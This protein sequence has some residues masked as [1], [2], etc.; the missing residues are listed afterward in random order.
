MPDSHGRIIDS[1]LGEFRGICAIPH[2]SGR[3]EK[4][5][6]YLSE[7]LQSLG[8]KVTRDW[9]GNILGVFPGKCKNPDSPWVML[10]A[11][12]DMVLSGD[13]A[14]DTPIKPIEKNDFII[15]ADNTTLGADNG[16]GI[17]VILTL[18]TEEESFPLPLKVL[19]TVEEEIGLKGAKEV[20]EEW[21]S[22]VKYLINTDGFDGSTVIV[23]CKGGVRETFESVIVTENDWGDLKNEVMEGEI[24]FLDFIGGH[25]GADI[26]KGRCNAIKALAELLVFLNDRF[27]IRIREIEGGKSH[28]AIPGEAMCRFQFLACD[29]N[30]IEGILKEWESETIRRYSEVDSQG[31]LTYNLDLPQ[32]AGHKE[33]NEARPEPW[34]KDTQRKVIRF[35][36]SIEDGVYESGNGEV[37]ASSNLGFLHTESSKVKVGVMVRCD[38]ESTAESIGKSHLRLAEETGFSMIAEGYHGWQSKPG[39]KL[40][41]G[42]EEAYMDLNGLPIRK[43]VAKVGLETA[44]FHGISPA[45]EM[46]CLGAD[47]QNA[48][49]VKERV[50]VSSLAGFYNLI[51]STLPKLI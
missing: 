9:K 40:L 28:N 47:I 8:G 27:R 33:S 44:H 43:E 7:K 22:G 36:A 25:S 38:L 4:L 21:F 18:L 16:I 19:F 5:G 49:S 12:M 3:E 26:D 32:K 14:P 13:A 42:V 30:D 51:K 35:L 41:E 34:H 45:T 1:I 6:Q 23:G 46:V 37:T 24:H 39:S 17:S 29:K 2:G 10:Q 48:H 31:R 20:P 11:H 15:A 50:R